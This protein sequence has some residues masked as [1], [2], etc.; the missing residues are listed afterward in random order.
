MTAL[1]IPEKEWQNSGVDSDGINTFM[2]IVKLRIS[3]TPPA[4]LGSERLRLSK[5][6]L[7]YTPASD[8]IYVRNA[9]ASLPA[10]M[11]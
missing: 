1:Q 6:T 4:S 11:R 3:Y 8:L 5:G 2:Y 10:V 9:T 7:T